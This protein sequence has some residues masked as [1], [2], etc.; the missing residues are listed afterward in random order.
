MVAL[1]TTLLFGLA[2][3]HPFEQG[4]K[5]T[6]F[7]AA[8]ILLANNGYGFAGGDDVRWAHA[9]IAVVAHQMT[10][11]EFGSLLRRFVLP[12]PF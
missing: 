4:N 10:E 11:A 3:N 5:R 6:A 2:R 1:A 7:E 8:L 9:V 12:V